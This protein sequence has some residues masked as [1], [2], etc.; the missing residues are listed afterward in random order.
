[1]A[2]EACVLGVPALY[3]GGR[4]MAVNDF[5]SKTGFFH[6]LKPDDLASNVKAIGED[7]GKLQSE[8]RQKMYTS[9]DDLTKMVTEL[10]LVRR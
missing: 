8:V 2:R 5:L 4:E 10:V 1:M 7:S 9:W 6:A 3:C